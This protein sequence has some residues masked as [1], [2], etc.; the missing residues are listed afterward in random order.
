MLRLHGLTRA[1]FDGTIET[2]LA[3]LHP[4]DRQRSP[5]EVQQAVR[6]EKEFDAEFRVLW[7][8]G[9]QHHIRGLA[10]VQRDAAG[11]PVS[12][13]GTNWDITQDKLAEAAL[14][15]SAERHRL[16][17]ET[18]MDGFLRLDPEGRL[19]EVN[20]TYAQMSGFGAA[21]LL[22][23]RIGDLEA[24]EGPPETAAHIAAIIAQGQDRFETRHRR[25]DGS[26]Y[27]VEISVQ[28]RP[29][30]DQPGPGGYFLAFLRDI[31]Q[32]KQAEA[33][34]R[35]LSCAVEQST[36]TMVLTNRQ[37]QITFVNAAFTRMTGYTAAEALGQTPRVLKS[38]QQDPAFYRRLW[39]TILAG[40]V[41]R[42]EFV[43]KRKD[44]TC[45]AEEA[46]ITPVRD[47][48]GKIRHFLAVKQDITLRKLAEAELLHTLATERELNALKDTFVTSMSHEFRTPLSA[49]LGVAEL[50]QDHYERL[51][52]EK[53]T[54][55]FQT[56][57][58][59]V[60][61]L[62]D[63]LE[64]VLLQGQLAAGGVP[65]EPRPTDV[66][67]LCGR[68]LARVQ[69]IFPKHPPAHFEGDAP[70]PLSLVDE[71]LLERVLSNLLTN[72]FKYSPE[73]TPIDL[74][75]RRVGDQWEI[76]VHDRGI[77]VPVADVASLFSAFLRGGN[78][79]NI[80]GT[81]LGL[82]IARECAQVQGGRLALRPQAEPGTTFV[83][84]LPWRLAPL[85]AVEVV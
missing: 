10:R 34:L 62:T 83:F 17:I 6:G 49:I 32:R 65:F 48:D 42:G 78:V 79:G 12:L 24:A 8:D 30:P 23:L 44:G 39:Q 38:G 7:P 19:V 14:Q 40:Q 81:G 74:T 75:V 36:N 60:R 21:E 3:A 54:T 43:N 13:L 72:A 70:G 31:T 85:T 58:Q 76:A 27:D 61:R 50:L 52:P 41:W 28:Y 67:A 56:I 2:W 4:D 82:F 45:F 71:H 29:V 77:G 18:A 11:Q 59:E 55:Y 47:A 5:E 1:Q 9:S 80:K 37:G 33:Q 35:L 16:L 64:D 68:I 73:L 15:S 51:A 25:K 66:V 20:A 63:M 46:T 57:R 69:V 22:G 84:S 53:R 26:I